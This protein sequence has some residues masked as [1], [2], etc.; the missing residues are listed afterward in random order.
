MLSHHDVTLQNILVDDSGKPIALLDWKLIQMEP[1]VFVSGWPR[2]LH[3]EKI[4][5]AP[6]L[7]KYRSIFREWSSEKVKEMHEVDVREYEANLADY[8]ATKLRPE[9]LKEV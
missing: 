2:F 4:C 7:R 3:G 1:L 9:Y 6:S 8:I 5:N